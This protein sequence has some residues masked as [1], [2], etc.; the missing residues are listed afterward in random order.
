MKRLYNIILFIVLCTIMSTSCHAQKLFGD[1]ASM[2]G[3]TSVY[4]GK[5]LLRMAG[6]I[7]KFTGSV[8]ADIA[9]AVVELN[10]IEIINCDDTKAL[11]EAQ[12][13]SKGIIGN[14][15]MELLAEINDDDNV[16][17]YAKIIDDGHTADTIILEVDEGQGR[18]YSIIVLNGIINLDKMSELG[19]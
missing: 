15:N 18:E 10:S 9:K 6:G 4:V 12:L 1:V 3:V 2:P 14:L 16:N 5:A 17:I 11:K 7:G 19:N 8:D 13:R